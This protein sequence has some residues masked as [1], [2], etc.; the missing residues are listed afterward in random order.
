MGQR[1]LVRCYSGGKN[2]I[3]SGSSQA[4]VAVT[5]GNQKFQPAEFAYLV[6]ALPLFLFK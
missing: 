6:K 1:T 5:N 3:H 2:R 4:Q